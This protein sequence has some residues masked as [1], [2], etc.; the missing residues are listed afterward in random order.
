MTKAEGLFV[1]ICGLKTMAD[2]DAAIRAGADA[3]GFVMSQTSVRAIDVATAHELIAYVAGRATTT[4]VVHDLSPEQAAEIAGHTGVDVLQM[5]GYGKNDIVR[6]L[7]SFPRVWRAASLAQN[8]DL[9]VG[10]FGEELLLLDS[11]RAGSGER[12]DLSELV[13]RRPEGKWL[14]AGGL[15]P[16]NV[17][18]AVREAQPWGVDVS[19]GVE[20]EPGVKDHDLIAA[21]VGNARQRTP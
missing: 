15:S 16:D 2:I 12:W 5:H 19:S 10:A 20:S 13:A 4:L 3:V 11:P 18:Q 17:Q 21:F 9:R 6:V 8:P 1:K 7:S 14:L